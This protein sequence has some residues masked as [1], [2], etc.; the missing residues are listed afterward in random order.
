MRV[1]IKY[2]LNTSNEFNVKKYENLVI[3]NLFK[4][5]FLKITIKYTLFYFSEFLKVTLRVL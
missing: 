3:I 5:N 2:E 1:I 4:W